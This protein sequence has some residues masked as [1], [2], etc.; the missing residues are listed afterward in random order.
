MMRRKPSIYLPEGLEYLAW[1]WCAKCVDVVNRPEFGRGAGMVGA[2]AN[3][4]AAPRSRS[5]GDS[6]HGL[7]SLPSSPSSP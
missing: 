6:W 4:A 1:Q 7:S 5:R 3:F 2:G